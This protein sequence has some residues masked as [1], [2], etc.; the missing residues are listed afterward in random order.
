M[1]LVVSG[2]FLL[3]NYVLTA[4]AIALLSMLSI[5]PVNRFVCKKLN[6]KKLVKRPIIT[7]VIVITVIIVAMVHDQS[8]ITANEPKQE[9]EQ[10]Q[11]A[12]QKIKKGA[13]VISAKQYGKEWP[14]DK[15]TGGTLHC[16]NLEYG[17]KAVWLNGDHATYAINGTAM[18]WS[19]SSELLG[20][21]GKPWIIAREIASNPLGL[22]RLIK[23]GLE[24]CE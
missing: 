21:D 12:E 4:I 20:V 1:G 17:K 15:E 11:V 13:K 5:T 18:G 24:L 2:V 22:S 23:D 7:A 10:T 14:L 8:R 9:N 19:E 6:M 16:K 3:L